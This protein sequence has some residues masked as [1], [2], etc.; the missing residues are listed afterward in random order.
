MWSTSD[1]GELVVHPEV[2]L[3]G[4]GGQGLVLLGPL[5]SLLGLQSLVETVAVAT[6]REEPAGEFVN[7]E[8]LPVL[9]YIIH[10]FTEQ[11]KGLEE[12]IDHVVAGELHL[13]FSAEML[14]LSCLLL[15]VQRGILADSLQLHFE[16]RQDKEPMVV[17]SD[18]VLAPF[19]GIDVSLLFLHH[20][21]QGFVHLGHALG[22]RVLL[23][24]FF[25][26]F[27]HPAVF[28]HLKNLG[29]LWRGPVGPEEHLA[30]LVLLP[31][32]EQALGLMDKLAGL[33]LLA[34]E[35]AGNRSA[36]LLIVPDGILHRTGD[37]EGGAGLVNEDAVHLVHD[38]VVELPL[39]AV[40]AAELH[41]VPE[42]V[43]TELI[44][45]PVGDI[46]PVS[47]LP[48]PIVE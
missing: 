20:V 47:E 21:A 28:Q 17:S 29:M 14:L 4:H 46:G 27:P 10:V 23:L 7:D 16:L 38:G 41:V 37:D 18:D 36:E 32:S 3:E 26:E 1:S 39:D 9:D 48:L 43:E 31:R 42:V 6:T 25:E 44:I 22:E 2:V 13:V 40:L 19:G 5:D 45:G 30:G 33:L 15:R 8:D 34:L 35:E 12:L 24:D 11:R